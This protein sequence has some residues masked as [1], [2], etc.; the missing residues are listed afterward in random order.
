MK[1]CPECGDLHLIHLSSTNEKWCSGC[2]AVLPWELKPNQK[3]TVTSNRDTRKDKPMPELIEA[4]EPMVFNDVMLDLETLGTRPGDAVISVG[5]AMFDRKTRTIGPVF[6]AN[7]DMEH[8]FAAGLTATGGT[9]K[10]WFEQSDE[11]RQQAT[12]NP[13]NLTDVLMGLAEFITDGD[14]G[15]NRDIKVWGNGAAFDNPILRTVYERCGM[16]TPWE[17]WNDRCFRTLRA[18]NDPTRALQPE[19]EGTRHNA[20]QDA[21]HQAKWAINMYH[22][23]LV[24]AGPKSD[25]GLDAPAKGDP[26]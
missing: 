25:V 17:H 21:V 14:Y 10:W 19:F 4:T 2:G 23:E 24:F 26:V 16:A 22:N 20:S 13:H 8:A 9:L 18:E 15:V 3:P 6:H 7:V 11:A 1:Q 12:A 5:A